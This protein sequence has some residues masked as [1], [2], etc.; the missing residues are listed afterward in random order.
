MIDKSWNYN[1]AFTI[2]Y[3]QISIIPV[4]LY[5]FVWPRFNIFFT[6]FS[7]EISKETE[8]IFYKKGQV[9]G[10]L[11]HFNGGTQKVQFWKIRHHVNSK[12]T[13]VL[14]YSYVHSLS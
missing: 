11:V 3:L 6:H 2:G 9:S 1:F 13:T 7:V 8:R 14:K 5:A 10:G 4:K 12:F